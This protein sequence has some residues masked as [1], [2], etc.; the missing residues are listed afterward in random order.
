MK[1]YNSITLQIKKIKNIKKKLHAYSV[2]ENQWNIAFYSKVRN[3]FFSGV[4][5]GRI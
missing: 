1:S 5:K 3:F 4:F 2:I